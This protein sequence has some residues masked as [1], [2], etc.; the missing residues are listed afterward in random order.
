MFSYSNLLLILII[1]LFLV[2]V[3]I[4]L[5]SRIRR[6]GLLGKIVKSVGWAVLSLFVV[7]LIFDDGAEDLG[8]GY[9][10]TYDSARNIIGPKITVPP[11]IIDIKYDRRFIIVRQRLN[12]LKPQQEYYDSYDYNYPSLYGDYYWSID[13]RE[14]T[15][16]GPMDS[17]EY[18]RTTDSL[19]IRLSKMKESDYL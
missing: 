17:L 15:F 1:L 11:E 4:A 6:S 9:E 16:Y 8:G 14:D 5:F 13:K 7:S 19:G 12:G 2:I 10:Y 18:I 3:T